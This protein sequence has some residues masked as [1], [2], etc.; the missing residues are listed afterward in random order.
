MG[1]HA[2]LTQEVKLTLGSGANM[3]TLACVTPG[4][5]VMD[6]APHLLSSWH[7]SH[8]NSPG[9]R[10]KESCLRVQ[11]YTNTVVPLLQGHPI[12]QKSVATLERVASVESGH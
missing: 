7:V 2:T 9:D 8:V 1:V 12:C 5:R 3:R 6:T 4:A 10:S 11:Y